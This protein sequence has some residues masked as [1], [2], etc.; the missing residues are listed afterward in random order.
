VAGLFVTFEGPEGAGKS[1]QIRLLADRLSASGHDV[2]VTREPGGT[3][4]GERIRDVLLAGSSIGMSPE[5]EALLMSAARAQHVTEVIRPSL[6]RNQIVLCDRYVDSTLAYQGGGRGLS[7]D[8]LRS[9]QRFA[10]GGLEPDLRIL[11]DL[12]VEI[13]LLRRLGDKWAINRLDN[14]DIAFHRR[15]R[16]TYLTLAQTGNWV[17]VDAARASETIAM[18]VH[19]LVLELL[20]RQRHDEPVLTE[21]AT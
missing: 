13:G 7:L 1:T 6:E 9:L 5:T 19:E 14:E 11:L 17:I 8:D 12:P 15:V 21:S 10:T 16:Q 18:D 3:E 20:A 4:I 2:R